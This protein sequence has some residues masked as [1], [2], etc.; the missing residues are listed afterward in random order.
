MEAR[1]KE[2]QEGDSVEIELENVPKKEESEKEH[3]VVEVKKEV[4]DNTQKKER[5]P[6]IVFARALCSIGIVIHHFFIHSQSPARILYTTA[7]S[8]WGFIFVTCFFAISGAV[9]YYN[10]RNPSLKI[11]FYRRWKSIFPPF[12]LVFLYFHIGDALKRKKFFY[13]GEPWKMLLTLTGMDGLFFYKYGGYYKVGEWFLGAIVILYLVYPLL[14]KVMDWNRFVL[15]VVLAIGTIWVQ[16]SKFFE[17]EKTRNVITCITSFY[18]GMVAIKYKDF[19]LKD[20][21][22][23]AV[24]LIINLFLYFLKMPDLVCIQQAQ[25]ITLFIAAVQIGD[26]VMR[27]KVLE[28]IFAELSSLSFGVFLVHH[29]T[30]YAFNVYTNPPYLTEAF[31]MLFLNLATSFIAS[32]VLNLTVNCLLH[33]KIFKFLDGLIEGKK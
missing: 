1:K 16:Q 24:A 6:G 20:R 11:F 32:K 14:Q 22:V 10:Y 28:Y 17:I 8:L 19:F 18:F 33:N 2:K 12:Y 15:P 29:E 5:L 25:G 31:F 4:V 30:I 21:I 26:Y 3:V 7:N 27:L 9:L 13:K 23:G